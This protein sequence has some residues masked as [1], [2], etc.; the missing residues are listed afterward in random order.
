MDNTPPHLFVGT[1]CFGGQ[2][3]S[4]YTSSMLA[5]QNA[6]K[7]ARIGFSVCLLGGDALITRARN[8]IVTQFLDMPAATHLL[9]IDADIGFTP[10]A[11]LRL[12]RS[13]YPVAAGV[14]P[15]KTLN[16]AEIARRASDPKC[17]LP[18][19][20]LQYVVDFGPPEELRYEEGFCRVRYA[21]TGFLLI[22][23]EAL[24]RLEQAHPELRYTGVHL[25]PDPQAHSSHRYAFFDG[26]IAP[27]AGIYL[28]E[29]YT[30]CRRWRELGGEIWV[31]T[32]SRLSHTGSITLTGDLRA[33]VGMFANAETP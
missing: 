1:P 33:K 21:G 3:S 16:W 23:R 28:S 15:A 18:E 6:C 2:V 24:L 20:A 25:S 4:L 9:F 32:E 8:T 22:A 12:L 11:A 26:L 19:S 30:F 14:Y 13:G 7:E 5:L 31:D 10:E 27:E 17:P 29:D